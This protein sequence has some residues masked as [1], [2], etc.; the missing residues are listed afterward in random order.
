LLI[1]LPVIYSSPVRLSSVRL[2][3]TWNA[4]EVQKGPGG[5]WPQPHTGRAMGG[6]DFMQAL[7]RIDGCQ[8][9]FG[10]WCQQSGIAVIAATRRKPK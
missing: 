4:Y 7:G 1:S 3:V 2:H 10:W 6:A 8:R 5:D 9:I